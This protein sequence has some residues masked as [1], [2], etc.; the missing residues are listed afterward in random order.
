MGA[1]RVERL[2]NLL[3]C[4]SVQTYRFQKRPHH[5]GGRLEYKTFFRHLRTSSPA[6]DAPRCPYIRTHART[7]RH[8]HT[9]KNTNIRTHP[10]RTRA[11]TPCALTHIHTHLHACTHTCTRAR[12]R[13]THTDAHGHRHAQAHVHAH[14]H[15]AADTTSQYLSDQASVECCS[16]EKRSPSASPPNADVT[17]RKVPHMHRER[18]RESSKRINAA[19]RCSFPNRP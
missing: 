5:V 19:S 16:F 4:C 15:H 7:H 1:T 9:N 8:A 12:T 18:I 6:R 3:I 17:I 14:A 10:E 2:L 13:H 11:L